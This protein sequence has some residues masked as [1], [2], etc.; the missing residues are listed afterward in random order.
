MSRF[1]DPRRGGFTLVELLVVIAIIGILV[2]LLL[3]AV[4]AAREAARR[5]HCGNNLKQ[6]GLA[7]Q[8]YHDAQKTFPPGGITLGNCC[9]TKSFTSWPIAILPQMEQVSLFEYYD[10]N[11]YNEDP[12]QMISTPDGL[13]PANEFVRQQNIPGYN[14]PDDP[15]AG[16]LR[17]PESG[18][19]N[20]LVYRMSSYRGVGGKTN[21]LGW[22]DTQQWGSIGRPDWKGILHTV[23]TAGLKPEVIGR[24]RDGTSNTLMVGE[25]TTSSHPNRGT[26]WAYSY[27]SY[28]KSDV[29]IDQPRTLLGDYDRCVSIGGVGADNACKRGWGSGH[30]VVLQ[31]VKVDGSVTGLNK[32]IDMDILAAMAT[33]Y[34]QESVSD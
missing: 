30:P 2:S 23:D 25:M 18:P 7:L 19:G 5:T 1:S 24:V 15:L 8:N 13:K 27:A 11:V 32:T 29:T 17:Q 20:G 14:C 26:F 31:F 3:P 12:G 33:I 28:N 22:W 21:G 9:A 10:Q 34:G 4:Q 16:S 6:I